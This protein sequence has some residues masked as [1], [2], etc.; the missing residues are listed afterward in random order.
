MTAEV[1]T[2]RRPARASI[3]P[4]RWLRD[5]LFSNA[6]NTLL[7]LVTIAL[8]ALVIVPVVR[9]AAIEA[10]WTV[11]MTNR[12]LL[13]LGRFPIEEMWRLW[14]PV[15]LA[16][17]LAGLS[18]GLWA[19][20]GRREVAAGLLV[21][22]FVFVVLAQGEP[23]LRLALAVAL[24]VGGY[25][26]A[27]R[28]GAEAGPRGLVV[29]ATVAGWVLLIPLTLALLL[30]GEPVRTSLWGGLM[31]N[32][33]LAGV[34]IGGAFP[35]GVLFALGRTS[36]LPVVRVVSIAYI[37]L[38]RGAP[39][40]AWLLM[41]RFLMPSF[42]PTTFGLDDIDIVFRAMLVYIFFT[43]AYTAEI[44]RGGLQSLPRGQV[45][46]AQALGLS[47]LQTTW[48]IVLP[49]A[50][51]AVIPALVS[52]FITLYKDTSLV[53]ILSLMDLLGAAQAATEQREFFGRQREAL[54]FAA[55]VFWAGAFTMSRLSLRIEQRL[56]LGAR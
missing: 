54:L 31:L 52:Q 2:R 12:K 4:Q 45:E 14:P 15:W 43:A 47:A 7:T 55:A 33:V 3:T 18:T 56:G 8:I 46:A 30:L 26:L 32:L 27:N 35:F 16:G 25:S 10:D 23:A 42:L 9:W 5:N 39:L 19:R 1:A 53:F 48:L 36:S 49:Q 21:L 17:L 11:V 20:P 41:A 22:A 37:E 50:L 29:R 28:A 38:V 24:G 6:W 44:V 51:R 34:G 13:F 40:L